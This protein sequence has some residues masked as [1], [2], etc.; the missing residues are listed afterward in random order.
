MLKNVV[1]VND[2]AA[3]DGGASKVAITTAKILADIGI[4]VTFFCA[5]Q[6]IDSDLVNKNINVICLDQYDILNNPNRLKAITQGLWNTESMKKLSLLIKSLD[7]SS[8]LIHIHTWTK[9]LSSSIWKV[10]SESNI[11]IVLTT[12]D[13]FS[14][15]PN[16]GSYDYVKSKICSKKAMTFQCLFTNCD[17]RNYF[18]KVWRFL[19]SMIQSYWLHKVNNFY[20]LSIS[21]LNY[22]LCKSYLDK[23]VK[24]WYFLQNPIDLNKNSPVDIKSYK[25]YLFLGRLSKEKGVELFCEAISQLGLKGIVLGDGYLKESLS[26]RYPNIIF[27]GW[28]S[29]DKKEK[30][31][32]KGKAL[33][34]P[35]L[36]YE[37]A[38]LTI[39]EMKSYGIPCIVPDKCAA[40][41]QIVDGKTGYIFK[42]GDLDSLK[43]A[44]MKY[45]Q[46]DLKQMQ[47]NLLDS[48]HPEDLSRETHLKKL[49]EIYND[50]LSNEK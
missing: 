33:V 41:E 11:P 38:P 35:S 37:G 4:S 6:P 12:H 13:Y 49:I 21:Q 18:Q 9:A 26:K 31:L 47:V 16:G 42:T 44:I 23:Y 15:C 19:R 28:V 17:S 32:N 27:T 36:W 25:S 45:E 30:L 46:T 40:S 1:I 3:V 48:F 50:I 39:Q 34:F 43:A 2:F 14:F 24:K 7:A 29:G 5:V 20:V 22:R 10:F 8:S